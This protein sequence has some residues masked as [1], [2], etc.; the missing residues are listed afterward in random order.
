MDKMP[1]IYLVLV[2]T[3]LELMFQPMS[4]KEH[5]PHPSHNPT[6]VDSYTA[7]LI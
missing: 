7:M 6:Q 3:L 2:L 5:D 1:Y 4:D